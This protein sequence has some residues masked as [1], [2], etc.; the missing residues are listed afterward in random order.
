MNELKIGGQALGID[1]MI[2]VILKLE[3]GYV[4]A[5]KWT[6]KPDKKTTLT[7]KYFKT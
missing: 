2:Y 7:E 4:V 3:N 1:G 5:H 6:D